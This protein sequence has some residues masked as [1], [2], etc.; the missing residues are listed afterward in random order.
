MRTT[1]RATS[2]SRRASLPRK[3]TMTK[4]M[5]TK[6]RKTSTRTKKRRRSLPPK[7]P[8]KRPGGSEP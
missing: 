6:R 1:R 4:R 7:T 8:G 5:R 3:T 2:L